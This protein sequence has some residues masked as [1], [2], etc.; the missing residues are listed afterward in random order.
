MEAPASL[1]QAGPTCRFICGERGSFESMASYG[2]RLVFVEGL[3]R[4]H[5]R[6]MVSAMLSVETGGDHDQ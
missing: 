2:K 3:E 6:E 1:K 4:R 5:F